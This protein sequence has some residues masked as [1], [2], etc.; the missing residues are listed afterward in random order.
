MDRKTYSL[1]T[2][3]LSAAFLLVISDVRAQTDS[4]KIELASTYHSLGAHYI[5]N[6]VLDSAIHYATLAVEL[7]EAL[8]AAAP[9]LDLGKSNHNTGV[10]YNRSGDYLAAAPYLERGIDVFAGLDLPPAQQYRLMNARV[11]LAAAKEGIGDYATARTLLKLA[12]SAVA[13]IPELQLRPILELGTLQFNQDSLGNAIAQYQEV[14][15]RYQQLEE[16]NPDAIDYDVAIAE[17][18]ARFNLAN[19]NFRLGNDS[20][21]ESQYLAVLPY[22]EAYELLPEEA[23]LQNNLASLY[24]KSR[25]FQAANQRLITGEQKATVTN[26]LRAQAQNA[27]HRGE[28]YLAQGQAAAAVAAQQRALTLLL[29]GFSPREDNEVPALDQLVRADYPTD[30][31]VYLGDLA[32][33]IRVRSGDE[34]EKATTL[35]QL[36]R[37]GDALLDE[38]RL[39]QSGQGSKFFWRAKTNTFYEQA[40]AHCHTNQLTEEAF[41]FFEK[42]KAILLHEALLGND[43]LSNLPDSLRKQDI[44]LARQLTKAKQM[45]KGQ[46]NATNLNAE[47]AAQQKLTAFRTRLQQAYP[48][49]QAL[50]GRVRLP[51]L[52]SFQH[53]LQ[54]HQQTLV[55]FFFGTTRVYALVLDGDDVRTVDLGDSQSI[56]DKTVNLLTYFTSNSEIPNAPGRYAAAALAL[57]EVLLQPLQLPAKQSL[58]IIPDGPL[59]YL[60]FPA[61]L[62]APPADVNRL[63]DFPYLLL[64]HPISYGHSASILSRQPTTKASGGIIAFAPFTDGTATSGYP[65][66]AFSQDEL[67][68][69]TA[70]YQ[71]QLYQDQQ[72]TAANFRQRAADAYI[73]HLSTHAFGSTK[74]AEP[75]IAFYDQPL[76]L[77]DLY[78]EQ[79]SAE[80]VV[81]S[82]CQ[83]NVGQLARG[84]GVL[85]LGRGFI[86]AGAQSI[87]ASLWNVNAR[88]SGRVLEEFYQGL[89]TGTTTGKALHQAQVA[90]LRNAEIRDLDKSPYLWAGLTYYGRELA[91]ALPAKRGIGW[92]EWLLG[93][94]LVSVGWFFYQGLSKK[95]RERLR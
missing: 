94:L 14:N 80:L 68:S 53:Q 91:L 22:L 28:W 36:Y 62:T 27:S 54:E 18:M 40:I 77:R 64:R 44:A 90:Y 82:A 8:F 30:V 70:Q 71:H 45:A 60:P 58:V 2:L 65:T 42:S 20:L 75:L 72:A 84:E 59:T 43:A 23:L 93:I 55:H 79:L 76:Y 31:F 87:I 63:G 12:A 56:K 15:Q 35:L 74:A 7:R 39:L 17:V 26:D 9:N 69:I 32:K 51:E 47:V 61:L 16:T 4:T 67:S 1:L 46:A 52:T 5:N 66:L 78:H 24:T 13:D 25:Q 83:T 88:G 21:A 41:L 81:L 37:T 3:L 86:Q 85:G 6:G 34:R 95:Q 38:L 48:G 29:P 11:E 73:L 33:A 57:Y 49:Y 89:A 10:A 19:T 50:T 92:R